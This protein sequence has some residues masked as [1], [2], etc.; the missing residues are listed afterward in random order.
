VNECSVTVTDHVEILPR[1]LCAVDLVVK[2][3]RHNV[4]R[5]D[6]VQMRQVHCAAHAATVGV[7][8]MTGFYVQLGTLQ[9]GT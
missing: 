9:Y 4:F 3:L 7:E 2:L 6:V 1:P 8:S 5:V